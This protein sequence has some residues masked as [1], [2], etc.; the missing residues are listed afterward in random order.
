M[1][2]RTTGILFLVAAALGAFVWFYEIRGEDARLEAEKAEKQLFPDVEEDAVEWIALTTTDGVAARIER[3]NGSWE[4]V[5][6]L[7]FPSDEF[8]ADGMASALA[9]LQSEAVYEEPQPPRVYGL[10][11]DAREVRFAAGGEE[12]AL[13]LG[14]DTPVGANAYASVAGAKPVYSVPRYRAQVF[15]KSLDDLR[16]KRILR[17]DRASIDRVVARWPDGGVDVVRDGDGWRLVAPLE[18]EADA[19]TVDE[20]LSELSFLRAEGFVDEPLPDAESGLDEPEFAVELLGEPEEEG[21]ERVELSL[22]IGRLRDDDERLARAARPTL[23]RIPGHRL[24]SFPREVVKYRFRTL[25]DF[26]AT[27]AVRLDLVFHSAQG[28][29]VGVTATRGDA[30]W[31]ATPE[32]FRPGK[33]ARLVSEL[34][35]LDAEDILAESAGDEEQRGLGLAPPAVIVR[36]FGAAP[37]ADADAGDAEEDAAG[38]GDASEPLLAEIHI[39]VVK[40]AD[41][42]VARVPGRDEIYL[43]DR[44]LSEHVPVDLAAFRSRFAST[45]EPAAEEGDDVDQELSDLERELLE[46]GEDLG[47]PGSGEEFP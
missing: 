31:T 15:R 25:A 1:N 42:I 9:D 19:E 28:E 17:F 35:R 34:S 46:Q 47:I 5:E 6:P 29:T 16:E 27:D 43:L 44:A 30:G 4:L 45:A 8:A 21:E 10:D 26:P 2:P 11:D 24:E 37:D 36:A 12:R 41:G 23:Y 13:R 20:L 18:A 33:I 3:S 14:N 39:G 32:D 22:A 40:G 38:S 7:S